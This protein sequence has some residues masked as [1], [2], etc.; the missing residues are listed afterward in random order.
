[1]FWR[2]KPVVLHTNLVGAASSRTG[3]RH[4][5]WVYFPLAVRGARLAAVHAPLWVQYT[6]GENHR[7]TNKL[8]RQEKTAALKD[9]GL[10]L[11]EPLR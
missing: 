4:N 6:Y 9:F 1:V 3:R 7:Q 10:Q 8:T 5:Y 2:G 11:F